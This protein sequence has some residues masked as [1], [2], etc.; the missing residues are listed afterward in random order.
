MLPYFIFN[1][2]SS[3]DYLIIN[4]LPSVFKPEKDITKIEIPGRDGFLTNDLGSYKSILKTVE[5]TIK[6][7]SQIDYICSWLT[8]SGDIVFSN[9]LTKKI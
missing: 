4:T 7:L 6:D 3:A 2:V 9:E 8:G 1:G 5:C